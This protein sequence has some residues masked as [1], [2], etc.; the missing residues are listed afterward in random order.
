MMPAADVWRVARL[1]AVFFR[2]GHSLI[3]ANNATAWHARGASRL[4]GSEVPSERCQT[5]HFQT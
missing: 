1:A 3:A 4:D 2:S 5:G